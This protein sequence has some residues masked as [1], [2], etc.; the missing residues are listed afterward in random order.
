MSPSRQRPRLGRGLSSL[1]GTSTEI[2]RPAP[3]GQYEPDRQ[4]PPEAGPATAAPADAPAGQV[5]MLPLDAI[6]PNPYQPRRKFSEQSLEELA[7]SIRTHGL[8]QP[9]IVARRGDGEADAIYQLIAGERRLRAAQRAG[10]AEMPCIVRPAGRQ[11]MLELAVIENIHRADLNPVERAEAYRGL[12]DHFGLT[13]QQVAQ[14]TGQP[15]ATVA[16][17]LRMLELCDTVQRLVMDGSLSF[18]HAKV[19]AGLAGLPELQ[20]SLAGR[21]VTEGLS[22]RDLEDL[23]RTAGKPAPAGQPP[24]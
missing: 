5:V 18:G 23:V 15:R 16:N 11:E 3:A 10:V 12:M 7:D 20:A 9:V 17:Y 6:A 4:P 22:V 21:T 19:L 14:R 13:Q 1:I 24:P 2:D 8:L